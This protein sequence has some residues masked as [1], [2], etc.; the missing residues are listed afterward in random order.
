MSPIISSPRGAL[1]PSLPLLAAPKARS[2]PIPFTS[3]LNIN[4]NDNIKRAYASQMNSY[5]YLRALLVLH[6]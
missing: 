1:P 5:T 2:L 3:N 4:N 6:S